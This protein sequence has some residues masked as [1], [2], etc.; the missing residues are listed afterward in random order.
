MLSLLSSLSSL[1]SFRIREWG[2]KMAFM[3]L[4]L[5]CSCALSCATIMNGTRQEIPVSSQPVGADVYLNGQ[6]MGKTPLK[7]DVKRRQSAVLIKIALEGYESHQVVLSPSIFG[8][9]WVWGNLLFVGLGAIV[10]AITGAGYKQTPSE[11]H[12]I[13]RRVKGSSSSLHRDQ[14][15]FSVT[16]SPQGN[17]QVITQ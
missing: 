3:L 6:L 9:G 7:L 16:L 2:G 17:L 5:S 14:I 1:S 12:G 10:D 11:V 8:S 13:L 15:Y 4:I